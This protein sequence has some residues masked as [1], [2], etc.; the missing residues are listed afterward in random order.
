MKAMILAAG[1]GTR[2]RPLTENMPKQMLPLAGKPLLEYAIELLTRHGITDLA[3]N[4][5]HCPQAIVNYFGSGTEWGVNIIYVPEKQL[6]GTAGAVK[7]MDWYLGDGPFLVLYGDNLNTCDLT[8]LRQFHQAQRNG[9]GL[10]T[11]ALHYRQDPTTSGIVQLDGEQRITRFVEKPGSD[12][13]FSHLVNAGLY[14][15]EPGALDYIP[16]GQFYDFGRDLFPR[17]LAEG[18]TLYGYTMSEYILGVDTIESYRQ[19]QIDVEEGRWCLT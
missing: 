4:L 18:Q 9:R 15:L 11:I 16:P 17:L 3:V 1:L 8:R 13:V 6:W 12:Q 14:I 7:R 2:L 5:Y 19:A 10:G